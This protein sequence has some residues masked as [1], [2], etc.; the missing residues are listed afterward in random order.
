MMQVI[1]CCK[2]HSTNSDSTFYKRASLKIW[3]HLITC[4]TKKTV[5]H[6]AYYKEN[7][8]FYWMQVISES[9]YPTA[10]R[11]KHYSTLSLIPRWPGN[12]STLIHREGKVN[13][14]PQIN[15]CILWPE[16]TEQGFT[17]LTPVL[18][19]TW[20]MVTHCSS[21]AYPTTNQHP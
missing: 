2:G 20:V 11:T 6:L 17:L 18:Y 9:Y 13:P 16:P 14:K 7:S 1:S 3:A 10:E 5:L 19:S 15:F 21:K 8:A 12:E 4:P